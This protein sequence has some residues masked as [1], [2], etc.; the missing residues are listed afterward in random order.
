MNKKYEDI[1]NEVGYERLSDDDKDK[2]SF[3]SESESITSQKLQI[4]QFCK[5]NNINL[6]SNY[7]DD[8]ITGLTFEREGW[9]Q[10]I[11]AIKQGKVDCVITKDLSRLG[12]DHSETGYY[13][14]SFFQKITLDIYLLT[15]TGL[16]NMIQW[17]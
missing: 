5:E 16:L 7:F 15:I 17:I 8:G 13:I 2:R 14:E 3:S 6:S 4:E 12:R 10:L 1:K 11:D 9:N